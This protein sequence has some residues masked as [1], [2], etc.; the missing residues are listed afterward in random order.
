MKVT[1]KKVLEV[2]KETKIWCMSFENGRRHETYGNV[3]ILTALEWTI[4]NSRVPDRQM[5]F[6]S[7]AGYEKCNYFF[8]ERA[9]RKRI[10]YEFIRHYALFNL[11]QITTNK[12]PTK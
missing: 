2:F 3:D 7:E 1:Q 4:R 10:S 9:E 6:L 11:G 5:L 12:P 8:W